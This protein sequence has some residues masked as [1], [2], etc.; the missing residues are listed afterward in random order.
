MGEFMGKHCTNVT[1]DVL[2]KGFDLFQNWACDCEYIVYVV[3]IC[4]EIASGD[5]V[6]ARG[7]GPDQPWLGHSSTQCENP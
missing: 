7:L 1:K 2:E 3:S 6:L 5:A 4:R